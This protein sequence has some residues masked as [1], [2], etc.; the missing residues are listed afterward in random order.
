MKAQTSLFKTDEEISS[1]EV[2]VE[3]GDDL[4]QKWQELKGMYKSE[5]MRRFVAKV[6]EMEVGLPQ[7][8]AFNR[9]SYR[10]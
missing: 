9:R 5:A 2:E 3:K 4:W 10:A 6:E 8:S 7:D 1:D